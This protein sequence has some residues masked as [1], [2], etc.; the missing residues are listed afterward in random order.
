VPKEQASE[1]KGTAEGKG[2]AEVA[3]VGEAGEEV[4]SPEFSPERPPPKRKLKKNQCDA[5]CSSAMR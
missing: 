2:I 1:G 4:S 5:L 3:E